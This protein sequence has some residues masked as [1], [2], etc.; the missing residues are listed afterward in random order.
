MT[1]N[2]GNLFDFQ[3]NESQLIIVGSG[4]AISKVI[5]VA[6]MLKRKERGLDQWNKIGYK[7]Y[8]NKIVIRMQI[9][10]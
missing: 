4:L 6:E 10:D 7:K 2:F 1:I 8:V 5:T 9:C 3:Q